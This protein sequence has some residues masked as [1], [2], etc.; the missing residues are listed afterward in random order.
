MHQNALLTTIFVLQT[1]EHISQCVGVRGAGMG[2]HLILCTVLKLPGR[3]EM[4]SVKR[5]E[6]GIKQRAAILAESVALLFCFFDNRAAVQCAVLSG[7]NGVE[8]GTS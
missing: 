7:F 6:N 5:A 4:T 3:A 8:A 2:M 1:P